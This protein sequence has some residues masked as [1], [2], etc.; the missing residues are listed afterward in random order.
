[1]VRAEIAD[2]MHAIWGL[3]GVGAYVV[4][5]GPESSWRDFT[6]DVRPDKTALHSVL[7]Q[8]IHFTDLESGA[9]TVNRAPYEIAHGG[10]LAGIGNTIDVIIGARN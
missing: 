4:F 1:M 6:D 5:C 8:A 7:I 9:S 2:A 3:R 10:E